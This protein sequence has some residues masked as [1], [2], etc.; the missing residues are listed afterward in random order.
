MSASIS[1]QK[2]Y[3]ESLSRKEVEDGLRKGHPI[4]AQYLFADRAK[5]MQ[6]NDTAIEALEKAAGIPE[7][8]QDIATKLADYLAQGAGQNAGQPG[9]QP[10]GQ[11]PGM[12]G[13][14]GQGPGQPMP[15]PGVPQVP[16]GA[17]GPMPGSPRMPQGGA[18]AAGMPMAGGGLIPRYQEGGSY[19]DQYEEDFLDDPAVGDDPFGP[20][21]EQWV[22]GTDWLR[23]KSKLDYALLGAGA[24]ATAASGGFGSLPAAAGY[25]G[26]QG[27]RGLAG[28][29]AKK[30]AP[31]LAPLIGRKTGYQIPSVSSRIAAAVGKP[32]V[33]AAIRHPFRAL[34]G[35]ISSLR[36][37][38]F[39]G[40]SVG[41]FIGRPLVQGSVKGGIPGFVS[42]ALTGKVTPAAG[43]QSIPAHKFASQM[44]AR[45]GFGGT[46]LAA[47][48]YGQGRDSADD[49]PGGTGMLEEALALDIQDAPKPGAAYQSVRDQI[50]QFQIDATTPNANELAREKILRDQAKRYDKR[51]AELE[52]LQPTDEQAGLSREADLWKSV[53]DV[54]AGRS[55]GGDS[56]FSTIG[57]SL[58]A[59]DKERK[60][61]QELFLE[62]VAGMEDAQAGIQAGLEGE[63]AQRLRAGEAYN[64]AILSTL[65]KDIA[66]EQA[67]KETDVY[68][69][70]MVGKVADWLETQDTMLATGSENY[71][72]VLVQ[73]VRDKLLRTM[74]GTGGVADPALMQALKTEGLLGD[75]ESLW[76]GSLGQAGI[77]GGGANLVSRIP[78]GPFK[79]IGAARPL[80]TGAGAA[81]G[82]IRGLGDPDKFFG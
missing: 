78:L 25:I 28:Y 32:G 44:L 41:E 34:G 38:Q 64:Q 57:D 75:E 5:R 68:S 22:Y 15:S 18:M 59:F 60:T 19:G 14:P 31:K 21:N 39:M 70:E 77:F 67:E 61:E 82:G 11:M 37:P 47:L 54:F 65:E 12:P 81:F 8:G 43:A 9:G 45:M 50:E 62:Q 20:F 36:L 30:I 55:T 27:L 16:G 66:Y 26:R 1:Q 80:V 71:D 4:I 56:R 52:G 74:I 49:E 72:P 7:P 42:R 13:M 53:S 58:R 2:A 76:P 69:A 48:G 73:Q 10:G 17:G 24:A 63:L 33:G 51:I 46:T 23:P 29:G 6:Q 40:G 79:A 3:V 35:G